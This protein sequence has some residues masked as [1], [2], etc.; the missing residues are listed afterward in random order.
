MKTTVKNTANK[1][2]QKKQTNIKWNSRLFFQI[3]VIVSLLLI[4][5]LMQTNLK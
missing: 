2:A 3:G 5:F 4:F 1:R